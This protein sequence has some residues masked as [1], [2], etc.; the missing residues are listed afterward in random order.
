MKSATISFVALVLVLSVGCEEAGLGS[1]KKPEKRQFDIENTGPV[2]MEPGGTATLT[3]TITRDEGFTDP[4]TLTLGKLPSSVTLV[5]GEKEV[6]A[7]KVTYTFK[8]DKDAKPITNAQ[9]C[10]TVK[11]ESGRPWGS[12]FGLTIKAKPKKKDAAKDDK[13]GATTKANG[14]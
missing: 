8:A 14:T 13:A 12:W 5:S 2:T 4:V 10:V 11:T 3:V 6:T 1:R 7:D 9:V